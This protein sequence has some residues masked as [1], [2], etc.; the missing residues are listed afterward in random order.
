MYVLR[1]KAGT[2]FTGHLPA[3]SLPASCTRRAKLSSLDYGYDLSHSSSYTPYLRGVQRSTCLFAGIPS[4]D[5]RVSTFM[6]FT[7]YNIYHHSNCP[8]HRCYRRYLQLL[9]KAAQMVIPSTPVTVGML[10]A[11]RHRWSSSSPDLLRAPINKSSDPHFLE[12]FQEW[13]SHRPHH[14]HGRR[15][16]GPNPGFR[17]LDEA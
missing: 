1:H 11:E 16:L 6:D 12:A 14:L 4:M 7:P 10:L 2:S 15:R 8:L 17:T 3:C 5:T 9:D 13:P